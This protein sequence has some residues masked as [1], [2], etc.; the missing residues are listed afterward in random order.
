M[1]FLGQ[2]GGMADRKKKA[3]SASNRLFLIFLL[4]FLIKQKK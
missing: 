4:L 2:P 1:L 3:E